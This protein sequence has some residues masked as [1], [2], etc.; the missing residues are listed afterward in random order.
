MVYNYNHLFYILIAV[1][2][3]F[4]GVALIFFLSP[5]SYASSPPKKVELKKTKSY[6]KISKDEVKKHN[7][8]DDAWIIVDGKVYDI[9]AYVELHPGGESILNNVGDDSSD[10]VHGPQHPASMWD[11]LSVYL[12]GE[13][14][15]AAS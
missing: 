5:S 6:R 1:V 7:T 8:A 13:L 9:S 10:G 14:D 2:T 4:V 11:V 3:A 12:I 15:T